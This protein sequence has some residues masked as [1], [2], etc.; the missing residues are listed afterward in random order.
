MNSLRQESNCS[1]CPNRVVCRCLGVTESA[2]LDALASGEVQTLKDIRHR[3]GAGDGCTCCHRQL[4]KYLEQHTHASPT[5]P[6]SS[7]LP[8]CS[9]R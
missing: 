1:H 5:L 4:K 9:L 6:S 7:A 8:I 3:T 2:V